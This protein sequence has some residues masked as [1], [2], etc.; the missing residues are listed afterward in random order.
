VRFI[1]NIFF[2]YSKNALAYYN[3]GVVAY[4]NVGVVVA[5]LKIVGLVP[6]FKTLVTSMHNPSNHYTDR[7]THLIK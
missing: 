7:H 6:A 3:V 5:F 4:Y 2:F 1:K